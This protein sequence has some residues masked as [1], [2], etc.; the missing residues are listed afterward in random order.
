MSDAP[1]EQLRVSVLG[2]LRAWYGDRELSL[3]PAR[4][5]SL[6][7]VLVADA[8]RLVSRDEIIEAVWGAAAPATAPG[9]V[10]TYISGLRRVLASGPDR[11]P[12]ADVLTSGP[13]G[14]ALRIAPGHLDSDRFAELCARAEGQQAAGDPATTAITLFLRAMAAH[15]LDLSMLAAERRRFRETDLCWLSPEDPWRITSPNCA[16]T[17]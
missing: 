9:S 16:C 10:Y 1:D 8:N 13:T 12:A 2:P 5:R 14:Y 15:V 7:A 11:R 17:S 3:G 4:Q 6:F